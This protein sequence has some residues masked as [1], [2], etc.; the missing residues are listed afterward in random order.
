MCLLLLGGI[1]CLPSIVFAADGE[2][3]QDKAATVSHSQ[4]QQNPP[5]P[6][7]SY[8]EIKKIALSGQYQKAIELAQEAL[9]QG[10]NGDIRLLLGNVYAWNK[11]FPAA[12][13]ELDAVLAKQPNYL[14]AIKGLANVEIWS[15]NPDKAQEII[16][17]GLKLNPKDPDLLK[18]QQLVVAMQKAKNAPKVTPPQNTAANQNAAQKNQPSTSYEQIR[19]LALS[20]QTAQAIPMAENYLAQREDADVRV[21]LGNMYA[22]QKNYDLAR[23]NLQ[24]VLNA[25]PKN[26]DALKGIINVE[27]WSGNIAQAKQ[28]VAQ[29]MQSY[30]QDSDLL[31]VQ[32]KIE[33]SGKDNIITVGAGRNLPA[34]TNGKFNALRVSHDTTW[35]SDLKEHWYFDVFEYT[36]YTPLGP[37][38]ARVNQVERFGQDG[39]QYEFDA[40]PTLGNIGYMYLNYGYSS[41]SFLPQNRY[42][43]ELFVNL[44]MAFEASGGIRRLQFTDSK[45]TIYTG[46]VGKYLGDWWINA[47]PYISNSQNGTGNTLYGT[48]RKYFTSPNAYISA[49]YGGG[50][51]TGGTILDPQNIN[52]DTT[53]T[54]YLEIQFPV[55]IETLI[56]QLRFNYTREA[57]PTGTIRELTTGGAGLTWQF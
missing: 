34:K 25:N 8:D 31:T 1:F 35:V 23:K 44:P 45:V 49:T 33:A 52:A 57:Y 17:R 14:D 12:R 9:K 16:N 39:T 56:L 22:W 38:L 43:S 30:P 10:D 28:L 51:G 19:K 42:G 50:T 7:P 3:A 37:I 26:I 21:L 27:F 47:R 18:Q 32:Q 4:N 48:V 41:A 15:N 6:A 13:Q 54:A 40:Y 20:G 36:R 55:F 2:G 29:A 53:Q 46:S 5:S 11:N 24:Q